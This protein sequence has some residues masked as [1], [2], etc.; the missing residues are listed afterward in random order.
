MKSLRH[1]FI[2]GR[3]ITALALVLTL[4]LSAFAATEQE[5][6]MAFVN[7]TSK[8]F[9]N[10]VKKAKPAVV[11][12][13][14]EKSSTLSPSPLDRQLEELFDHPMFE[15]FFGP[16]SKQFKQQP[17]KYQ[18]KGQGSGFIISRD[19]IILT[20]NHVVD[21]ADSISVTLSDNRVFDAQVIGTDPQTDVA[22]LKIN[23]PADLPVLPL[24]DSSQLQPGEWVIA[25]GNP[26]GLSQTV[27][28]GVVS[29]T[30]R[31]S[32]GINEYENF[33]QTDAAINPGNSGGPLLNGRGEAVG[34]NTALFS[35]T[36][37]YMGI[38]FAIPINMAKSIEQQLQKYG[39]VTRGWLGVVIQDMTADLA[40]SFGLK[41]AEGILVSEVAESSPAAQ[42]GVR[43]GDIITR[44]NA[45]SLKD[46]ADLR[47]HIAMLAPESKV[48]LTLLRDGKEK[49]ISVTIGEK[50]GSQKEGEKKPAASE[51]KEKIE[52]FGLHLQELNE[53]NRRDY[54]LGSGLLITDIEPNSPAHKAGLKPG[55]LVESINRKDVNTLNDLNKMIKDINKL[56]N[57]LL[58]IRDG[59]YS[60]FIVLSTKK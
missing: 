35:R 54:P 27:T 33:I 28:V 55:Q 12:I 56:E 47:N 49:T 51:K 9:I 29:A 31:N 15:Q 37:G 43:A 18:R 52:K 7:R 22:L 5:E 14:V 34:I 1:L 17:R 19:G 39:K 53:Q 20:N 6:D 24:G 45:A 8:A 44:I 50:P 57:L 48:N 32:I 3:L 59:Q 41:K 11:H 36:G 13:Q 38:G 26:F 30:G 46:V 60:I 10:I 4:N 58:R 40:T 42:A 2:R 16:Y 23:D 25:I 21:Q